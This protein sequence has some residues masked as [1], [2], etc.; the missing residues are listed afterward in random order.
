M[1]WKAVLILC[2]CFFLIC[3]CVAKEDHKIPI[4]KKE[5]HKKVKPLKPESTKKE[6]PQQLQTSPKLVISGKW[7]QV[8]GLDG[9]DM[10]LVYSTK[11]GILFASHGFSGVWRSEDGGKSWKMIYQEDF[12][13]VH[14]YD[15]EEFNGKL[16]AGSN[17]GLWWSNDNGKSWKK[18]E[19]GFGDVY[20]G[21]YHVVS[22]AGYGDKLFFTAVL[23]K[24][25]RK[26]K[27]GKGK[28]YHI[29]DETIKEFNTPTTQEIVVSARYPYLFISSP[30]SGLYVYD[31]GK[32]T[33]ILDKKTTRV[34]VDDEYNLYVGTIED[35]WY[36]GRKTSNGWEWEHVVVRNKKAEKTIF[37]FL[38]PDPANKE[39]LWFG[40][41]GISSF[42]SFSGRGGSGSSFIGTGCWDGNELYDVSIKPNFA[43]FLAFYGNETVNTACGKATKYAFTTQGGRAAIQKT[44]DGGKTWRSSYEGVYGDTI[45]EVNP[46]RDGIL[47]GSI[48]ITAVSGIEIAQDFGNSWLDVDFTIGKVEGKLPGYS[49]CAASPNEKVKGKYDL[50]ISTGYPSPFK[51]DGVFGVDISCIESGG[52]NCI[53]KLID[54]AHYEMA[55]VDN[56]LYAGNMDSG[57]DVLDLKT[58]ELSKLGIE[59][60]GTLVRVFDGKVFVGT[61]EG[62]YGGDSWRWNGEVG[63]VYM[64][65]GA[66]K[67]VYDKYVISFFVNN[68]EF[69]GLTKE[70]LV[71]KPDVLSSDVVEVKLPSKAYTDMEV[72][73]NNGIIFL[74]T[75]GEGVYYTTID[76]LKRGKVELTPFNDGLLTLKIRNLAYLDGYLFAGTQGCSVWRAEI[77]TN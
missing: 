30:Y 23:D 7:T 38:L 26:G 61:Y 64:C 40:C 22:L 27:P 29:E 6:S 31:G 34:F 39:R 76:E 13:D 37:Y 24:P 17:K 66:C 18:L 65:N 35:Y 47:K 51:G 12:V 8:E 56:E 36:I 15:M 42:Y 41:G 69:I 71:Y 54:G 48:V 3:G 1:K 60:A 58:L 32:W 62:K 19:T 25:F 70:N 14:F 63:K 21:K 59:G 77:S 45:N 5:K 67:V 68:G 44:E 28:L 46:I 16:Y 43:M 2:L 10:H 50:L 53:E 20:D 33:K 74:S 52:K 55:I 57:V 73:W 4:T 9:G 72:D 75:Y 11:D 49:W